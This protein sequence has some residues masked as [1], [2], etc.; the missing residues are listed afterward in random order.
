M[1]AKSARL[2]TE[3]FALSME[4]HL[5]KLTGSM[6]SFTNA[7]EKTKLQPAVIPMPDFPERLRILRTRSGLSQIQLAEKIGIN[8]YTL[9][10]YETDQRQPS[11]GPLCALADYF[12]VSVDYLLGRSDKRQ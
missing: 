7:W 8:V 11:I 5:R 6:R 1:A 9:R 10:A 2:G 4:N 12:H 3:I